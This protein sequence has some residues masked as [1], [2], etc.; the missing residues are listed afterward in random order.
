MKAY[1]AQADVEPRL[2]FS[3][4][5]SRLLDNLQ[6]ERLYGTSEAIRSERARIVHELNRLALTHL[7]RSFNEICEA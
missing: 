3:V 7:G 4:L 6:G 2:G 1:L 5:E